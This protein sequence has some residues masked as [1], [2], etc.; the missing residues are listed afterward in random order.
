MALEYDFTFMIDEIH[1]ALTNDIFNYDRHRL[2]TLGDLIE[3][4]KNIISNLDDEYFNNNQ[5]QAKHFA[6]CSFKIDLFQYFI[7]SHINVLA[8]VLG[9]VTD[10]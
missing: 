9:V 5:E 3:N 10:E 1:A 2:E 4:Y 7:K 6:H 8:H